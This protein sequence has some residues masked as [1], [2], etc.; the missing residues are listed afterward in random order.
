MAA[1]AKD[2][3]SETFGL[4]IAYLLPGIV[5]TV[6]LSFWS[7]TAKT[8]L[9]AF[10]T[11]QANVNLLLLYLFCSLA[12]GLLAAAMRGLIFERWLIHL[13]PAGSRVLTDTEFS[14]LSDENK[15][16]AFR[17]AVDAHYRYHQCWGA[18]AVALP[19]LYL[20]WA[21]EKYSEIAGIDYVLALA[22]FLIVETVTVWAAWDAYTKYIDRS[23]RILTSTGG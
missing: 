22:F 9:Q 1:D 17:A 8:A 23:R 19:V 3:T 2:I 11:E 18:M 7:K 5:G 20:G 13:R 16:A 14:S 6:G 15:L 21:R 12:V 4:V 10:N